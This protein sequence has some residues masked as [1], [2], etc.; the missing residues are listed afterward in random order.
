MRK[1][2]IIVGGVYSDGKK[3][4]RRVYSET[5]AAGFEDNDRVVYE[6]LQGKWPAYSH[7]KSE[8]GYPLTSCTRVAFAAWAKTRME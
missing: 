4:V 6:V 3:T 8:N 5:T 1:A 7:G 2:D